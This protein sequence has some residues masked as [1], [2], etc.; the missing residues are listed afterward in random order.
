MSALT[1]RRDIIADR[2]V[3]DVVRINAAGF[4]AKIDSRVAHAGAVAYG[5]AV[6]VGIAG[7]LRIFLENPI[8]S[9]SFPRSFRS[10]AACW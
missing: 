1:P 9:N 8:S 2:P 7:A 3:F 10:A 5:C 4:V 6:A